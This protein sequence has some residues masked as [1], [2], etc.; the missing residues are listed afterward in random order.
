M[1]FQP[2]AAT[3]K[4]RC[5]DA[6]GITTEAYA[7]IQDVMRSEGH[8]DSVS[9]MAGHFRSRLDGFARDEGACH[10]VKFLPPCGPICRADKVFRRMHDDLVKRVNQACRQIGAAQCHAL[11]AALSWSLT[12]TSAED[13]DTTFHWFGWCIDL[14]GAGVI[15]IYTEG[16]LF[17]MAIPSE[18]S[19]PCEQPWAGMQLAFQQHLHVDV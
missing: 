11:Q 2:R 5:Q 17:I 3:K 14:V 8:A 12:V 9:A 15:G 10:P 13:V 6:L 19:P 7:A 4:T 18:A 16:A 1:A